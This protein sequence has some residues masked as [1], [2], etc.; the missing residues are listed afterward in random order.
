MWGGIR[1]LS[2][3]IFVLNHP[4]LLEETR[5]VAQKRY[6]SLRAQCSAPAQQAAQEE[7]AAWR[8]ADLVKVAQAAWRKGHGGDGV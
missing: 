6:A 8:L 2:I 1:P 5:Q 3:L 4:A 7:A